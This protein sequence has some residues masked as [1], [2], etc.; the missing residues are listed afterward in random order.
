MA[1][2]ELILDII[3]R[4]R[5][6]AEFSKV[7]KS[8]DDTGSAF[9]SLGKKAIAAL[10]VGA[11]VAFG[12]ESVK[13][14]AEAEAAQNQLQQAFAKF[15]AL[16]DSSFESLTRL[17]DEMQDKA[18]IDADSLTAAD[19]VLARFELTGQ[20]IE[21]LTP[22]LVDYA[23]VSGKDAP[24]AAEALGKA[25]M[26]NARALK[27]LGIEFKPTGDRARDL[28][29]LMGLLQEKVGGAG[30]AFAQTA[31]GKLQ[32]FNL[33]IEDI[34][35][36]VGEALVP[37]LTELTDGMKVL[38]DVAPQAVSAF[39]QMQVPMEAIS[40][41][42]DA[43]PD[44]PSWM[45]GSGIDLNWLSMFA[46]GG[47]ALGGFQ[48][49]LDAMNNLGVGAEALGMRLDEASGRYVGTAETVGKLGAAV[50]KAGGM[51][52]GTMD[53]IQLMSGAATDA[54]GRMREMELSAGSL[55]EQ[56]AE[57]KQ[58]FDE[59][60]GKHRDM[61][62]AESDLN[63]AL[64]DLAAAA[65]EGL[66][67]A[68][69]KTKTGFDLTTESGRGAADMFITAADK[70][71]AA[72]LAAADEGNWTKAQKL[73]NN[74]RDD[75]IQQAMKWG[76]SEDAAR[77]YVDQILTVPPKV[78]TMIQVN[79]N[80]EAV[81]AVWNAFNDRWVTLHVALDQAFAGGGTV[82]GAGGPK[83]DRVAIS[84]S[85][86]EFVVQESS[87]RSMGYGALEY[88]NA[89]GRLPWMPV[90]VAGGQAAAPT[91]VVAELHID[92]QR[93]WDSL[94]RVRRERNGNQPLG[95]G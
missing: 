39:T 87:A 34:Q 73:I 5:A 80:I 67:P 55:E 52:A 60:T 78:A 37:L 64:D 86:G 31:Q 9:D 14:F 36:A 2:R 22:L 15:P 27:E 7:A 53:A 29:T 84:A 65:A 81:R 77:D 11:V 95:L 38:A 83:D 76:M 94:L 17:N 23:T 6:S 90:P 93:V 24:A 59:L 10:S 50:D 33:A 46:P 88:M 28:A 45:S 20:E 47:V 74:T 63:K 43:M 54:D 32:A 44:L 18:A 49:G 61:I 21:N 19:A 26:G 56:L 66:R 82:R 25:L 79:S 16:A 42:L 30:E 68:L 85:P 69:D 62:A 3:A 70:A 35:E 89:T 12:V 75:L 13:A 58:Q 40:S 57:L 41:V 4:D 51:F 71:E 92:G 91:T 1:S 8:S 48:A 72:A